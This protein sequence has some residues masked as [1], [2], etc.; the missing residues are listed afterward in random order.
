MRSAATPADE[1]LLADV[2]A[3]ARE[4]IAPRA[5]DMDEQGRLDAE[6]VRAIGAMRLLGAAWS[7]AYGGLDVDPVVYG[8][9][10]ETIGRACANARGLLTVCSMTGAAIAK[11]GNERQR[12]EWLPRIATGE[13]IAAFALSE[14][15]V[16]SD[17]KSVK[18]TYRK[19]G[20]SYVISGRKKWISFAGI[21]KL[22]VI[23]ARDEHG[24]VSAFLIE[25]DRPGLRLEPMRGLIAARGSHICEV[26]LEDVEVPEENLLGSPGTGFLYVANTALD[27]GR[28]SIAWGSVGIA[29]AALD[30]MIGYSMERSQF[31]KKLH[32]FQL[33][34]AFLAEAVT[35]VHA[36]RALCAHAGALRR[37]SDPQAVTETTM[38]K[39]YAS[40]VA[41]RVANDAVQV[42][43]GN[44]LVSDYPA[45]RLW[46][47]A[48]VLEIIEGSSQIQ[49]LVISKYCTATYGRPSAEARTAD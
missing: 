1:R 12:S 44:G 4:M 39:Y 33:V 22:L 28:Y 9:L 6:V 35:E 17:A 7:K 23:I 45:E 24:H 29:Q 37:D 2:A 3:L 19:R 41:N 38:A 43:G 48:R 27:H 32:E 20:S 46:R 5:R 18:T 47:E 31:G 21:A 16:G 34:K 8:A 14:P 11:C 40:R 49:Q 10:T 26:A 36:A 15:D 13:C 42:H 30:A 25:R